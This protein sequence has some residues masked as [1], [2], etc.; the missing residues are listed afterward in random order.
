[1]EYPINK[2]IDFSTV[3][4]NGLRTAIF[5]Q[6]CNIHCL[7]CHNPET[8]N[9]CTN[10]GLCVKTCPKNALE[11]RN[12]KVFWNEDLC[13]NCDTCIK[14]CNNNS[15]PKVKYMTTKEVFLEVLKNMPFIRGITVSGGEASLYPS[16]L[17]ELFIL[18]KEKNLSTL[19]DSNGMVLFENYKSLMDVTDGVM[20]DVKSWDNEV[21]KKLTGFDNINVKRNLIWLYNNHKLE[22]VRI[23]YQEDYVDAKNII[24]GIK[25]TILDVSNIK[26]KLIS[27]R[28]NGV[29][30]ILKDALS[31]SSELMNEL[32]NYALN[33]GF[34]NITIK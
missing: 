19:I 31:P 30:G 8:Q 16:F 25:D 34:I 27:F 21:Y 9:I 7:Y 32:Y 6:K 3:D 29:K 10:C 14:T 20:L 5:V 22:E 17:E 18:A 26:L 2:I 33:K 4:G 1:M 13:I 28:Q 11:K 12:G 15:S 24:D 23:V